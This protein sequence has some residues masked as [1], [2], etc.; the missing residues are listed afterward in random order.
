MGV[1]LVKQ[2][3]CKFAAFSTYSSSFLIWD[4]SDDE[5]KHYLW[6]ECDVGRRSTERYLE[7]AKADTV[8]SPGKP[9][10]AQPGLNRWNRA[11]EEIALQRGAKELHDIL[12]EMNIPGYQLAPEIKRYAVECDAMKANDATLTA[13][14]P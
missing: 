7:E 5:A 8:R 2:P 1:H 14:S 9:I 4:M 13:E 10:F 12:L 11:L 3:D 6:D